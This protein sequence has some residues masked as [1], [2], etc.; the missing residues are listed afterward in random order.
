MELWED[1]EYIQGK[2]GQTIQVQE[3][4]WCENSCRISTINVSLA[5]LFPTETVETIQ[6]RNYRN[7]CRQGKV[8]NWTLIQTIAAEWL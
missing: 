7:S 6:Y 5:L 4:V 3:I 1:V 8:Q 2:I